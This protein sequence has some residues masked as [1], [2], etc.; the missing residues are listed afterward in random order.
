MR[1]TNRH[2]LSRTKFYLAYLLVGC[3]S[4]CDEQ[5]DVAT[6]PAP[7]LTER[8]VATLYLVKVTTADKLVPCY[9][10]PDPSSTA[11]TQVKAGDIVTLAAPE[12]GL[13]QRGTEFWLNVYPKL[14]HRP[15]CYVNTRNLI[16][17]R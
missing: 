6:E 7:P 13:I 5:G 15:S 2:T 12:E 3:L 1:V 16:P 10:K 4:A 9:P 14:S 8:A 17:Y 11:M